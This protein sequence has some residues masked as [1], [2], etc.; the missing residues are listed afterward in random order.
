MSC[1]RFDFPKLSKY[2]WNVPRNTL[3]FMIQ[4]ISSSF[5]VNPPGDYTA[6][7]WHWSL[8]LFNSIISSSHPSAGCIYVS[9]CVM[10]MHYVP[11]LFTNSIDLIALIIF[12]VII[13]FF[14]HFYYSFILET[15]C[16]MFNSAQVHR[17]ICF[18]YSFFRNRTVILSTVST[19][20]R[21]LGSIDSSFYW[22]HMSSSNVAAADHFHWSHHYRAKCKSKWGWLRSC[23][24][25]RWI[26]SAPYSSSWIFLRS[27]VLLQLLYT[28]WMDCSSV[29]CQVLAHFPLHIV[30]I[31]P[32]ENTS[33]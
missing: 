27:L 18:L 8:I 4:T 13:S 29:A 21:C 11:H 7:Y 17:I 31:G 24:K 25:Q 5:R 33:V 12:C 6:Q 28:F 15:R 22:N 14:S 10:C 19:C 3:V 20:F 32:V 16:T 26:F 2:W 23:Q 9:V 1:R 30:H